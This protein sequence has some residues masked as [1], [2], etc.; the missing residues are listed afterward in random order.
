MSQAFPPLSPQYDA[1][2][3][4]VICNEKNG[5]HLTMASA[6]AR[7][8]ADP[9]NEAARISKLHKDAALKVLAHLVSSHDCVVQKSAG[10]QMTLEQLFSLL[11]K[12]QPALSFE[13]GKPTGVGSVSVKN[14]GIIVLATL[15][16]FI[17][18]TYLVGTMWHPPAADSTQKPGDSAPSETMH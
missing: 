8:G 5:M 9:W 1:F 3:Y 16:F 12:A 7:S 2:L 15:C 17:I 11:P 13:V 14:A 6:I 4:A 10:D 18:L